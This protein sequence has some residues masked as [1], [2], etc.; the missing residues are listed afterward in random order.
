[1]IRTLRALILA[2]LLL[3][4]ATTAWAVE[5]ETAAPSW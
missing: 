2:L 3:L 1:M 4:A 5:T